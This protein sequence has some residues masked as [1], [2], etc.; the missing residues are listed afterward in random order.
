MMLFLISRLQDSAI[1]CSSFSVWVNSRGLPTA[2][3]RVKRLASSTLRLGPFYC[4]F[5]T[6]RIKQQ[7]ATCRELWCLSI[8]A[9]SCGGFCTFMQTNPKTGSSEQ[10]NVKSHRFQRK[11]QVRLVIL[12]PPFIVL[13]GGLYQLFLGEIVFSRHSDMAPCGWRT[14]STVASKIFMGFGIWRSFE[15]S[16]KIQVFQQMMLFLGQLQALAI[17]C[18]FFAV[19]MNSRA[20][21]TESERVKRMA[22]AT[23]SRFSMAHSNSG[24]SA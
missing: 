1:S 16:G 15:L 22:D 13:A 11:C 21:P 10:W 18:S 17:S 8:V 20:V 24:S 19:R 6:D 12:V 9:E 2:T 7:T 5:P 14:G 23:L 3:A 4:W